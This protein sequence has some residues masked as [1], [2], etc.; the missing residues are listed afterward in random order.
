MVIGAPVPE[1]L[2]D[3][4][5]DVHV[6]GPATTG[7]SATAWVD[8][9]GRVGT[10]YRTGGTP[11]AYVLDPNL[12]VVASAA[13][14]DVEALVAALTDAGL[15]A[16]GDLRTISAQAPVLL[17]DD[18]LDAALCTELIR[19][20]HDDGNIATGVEATHDGTRGEHVT[21]VAKR[22]RDHTVSDPDL[23]RRLVGDVGRRVMSEVAKAFCYR[24][25]RFE[26]F[27][28]ARYGAEE[29]GFFTPHRDNLSPSTAHR[30]FALTVNL[31]DGYTGGDLRFPEYSNAL[32]RP[33]PG[34]AL[35]FSC[36]HLHEVTEVTDG[37]RFVLLS[38]LFGEDALPPEQRREG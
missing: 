5:A 19:T 29:R 4:D 28:I 23:M 25:T 30:R 35:V 9:E 15:A 32:H 3:I 22:R 7:G 26:G 17:I 31:N 24:A 16:S 21:D 36:A 1:G 37:E 20:W 12:R 8:S 33:R 2:G 27:K 14:D 18:V 13:P 6:V 38:F 34:G 10:A 11:T